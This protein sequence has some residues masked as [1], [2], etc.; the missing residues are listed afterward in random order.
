MSDST[1][2]GQPQEQRNG[3]PIRAYT[4]TFFHLSI[5]IVC[6]LLAYS[7]ATST[8]KN[9]ET[10]TENAPASSDSSTDNPLDGT[11]PNLPTFSWQHER[12]DLCLALLCGAVGGAI[13]ASRYVVHAVRSR[14]Y[15]KNR[16]LWQLTTPIHSGILAPIGIILVK[17]GILT[18]TASGVTQEPQYTYFIIG[19]SFVVGFSSESFVK[20]LIVAAESLFGERGDLE[21]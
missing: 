17:A 20:R 8:P 5:I 9:V 21:E 12:R 11:T 15:D 19:V 13:M 14:T 1:N 6:S 10:G 2:D 3:V 18:L 4:V 16:F 7:E